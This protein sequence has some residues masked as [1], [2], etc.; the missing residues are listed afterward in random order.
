MK[1]IKRKRRGYA[2]DASTVYNCHPV[3]RQRF[4]IGSILSQNELIQ[5]PAPVPQIT[6]SQ[7]GFTWPIEACIYRSAYLHYLNVMLNHWGRRSVRSE[8]DKDPP[9]A[10]STYC[11]NRS[12]G[13]KAVRKRRYA[14]IGA[15]ENNLIKNN[16]FYK[17]ILSEIGFRL[18]IQ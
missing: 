5:Y 18:I 4:K 13:L 17:L 11:K 8:L 16:D 2:F 12:E 1:K 9:F 14:M 15:R 3:G 7:L 6:F 10:Y